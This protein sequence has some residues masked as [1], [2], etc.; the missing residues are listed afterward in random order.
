MAEATD[1]NVKI[2]DELL[3]IKSLKQVN[4]DG[5][6]QWHPVLK[7]PFPL[8]ASAIAVLRQA[9]A[10]PAGSSEDEGMTLERMQT[11]LAP[12]GGPVRSV[13]VA[14]A[15][16]RYQLHGCVAEMTD[17]IVDGTAIRTIA[18]EDQ[19]PGKVIAAV[20]AMKLAHFENISYPIGLKRIIGVGGRESSTVF[21]QAVIDVGTNSV[22][23]HVESC[24]RTGVWTTMV[25]RAEVTRLGQG[26]AESGGLAPEAIEPHGPGDRGHDGRGGTTGG[27]RRDRRGHHGPAHG[28]E[29]PGFPRRR[30]AALRPGDRGH[31][32][33]DEG[34]IAYLAVLSGLG[35]ARG[36]AGH[37]RY[38]RRIVAIHVWPG[39]E[40]DRQFS[41]NVGAVR[42]T[43]RYHLDNA[44]Q[45]DTL[46]QARAAI[47]ADLAPLD[48]GPKPEALVGM[49]G[50]V[51]NLTAVKLEDDEI[52]SRPGSGG[53]SRSR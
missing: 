51:T 33:A 23:F 49:G 7:A 44:V 9:L 40:V 32:G 13:Y 39:N 16:T 30:Q 46:E 50:A 14:K 45:A 1:A 37:L 20:R 29:Q 35:L 31:L 17:V 4:A 42:F 53:D 34:R 19:D 36:N 15:R 47:A 3:D 8:A 5:L 48:G 11:E 10:L 12:S 38:R 6:E 52:R 24:A 21:R 2:R 27:Q 22:K 28:E 26:I 18:I 41:L 25:D 43:E